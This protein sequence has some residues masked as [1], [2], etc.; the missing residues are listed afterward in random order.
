MDDFVSSGGSTK[1]SEYVGM[2]KTNEQLHNQFENNKFQKV[3]DVAN[4]TKQIHDGLATFVSALAKNR[5]DELNAEHQKKM[6][7][8]Q[9]ESQMAMS[10]A[11]DDAKRKAIIEAEFVY[12][13]R[14]EEKKLAEEKKKASRALK[15]SMIS[16]AIANT[17]VAVTSTCA[18]VPGGPVTKAVAAAIV[19]ASLYPQIKS[20]RAQKF[21]FGR[22]V[23]G[24]S[25]LADQVPAM[26]SVG[27]YV[28][29]KVQVDSVGGTDSLEQLLQNAKG[30]KKQQQIIQHFHGLVTDEQ[31]IR[32][33][34][35]KMEKEKRRKMA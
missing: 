19:A 5:L 4:A 17:A 6:Q 29:P 21:M 34:M 16:Q 31:Y 9:E 18:S 30:V 24:Q 1:S 23:K 28:V 27:E 35:N 3:K 25:G 15:A 33:V 32:N 14:E 12:R 8:L 13:K 22:T 26:L 7:F 20:I 2:L 11:G 10:L